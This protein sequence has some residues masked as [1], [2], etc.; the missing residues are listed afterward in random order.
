MKKH[1]L[2]YMTHLKLIIKVKLVYKGTRDAK[3][4]DLVKVFNK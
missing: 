4:S 3:I 1:L 2:S